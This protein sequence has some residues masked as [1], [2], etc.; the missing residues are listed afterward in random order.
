VPFSKTC[1]NLDDYLA[2]QIVLSHP[3]NSNKVDSLC[4]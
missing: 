3:I 1:V 4:T 2:V